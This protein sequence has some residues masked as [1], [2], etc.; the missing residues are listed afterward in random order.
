MEA[1]A[2]P[3]WEASSQVAAS[4]LQLQQIWDKALKIGRQIL[5]PRKKILWP[6]KKI[7]WPRKKILWPRKKILWPRKKKGTNLMWLETWE[8]YVTS[9]FIYLEIGFRISGRQLTVKASQAEGT[10][11]WRVVKLDLR[12]TNLDEYGRPLLNFSL[13]GKIDSSL[14]HLQHLTYL[15]LSGSNFVNAIPDFFGSF[16]HLEYL[17]LSYSNF[18]GRIPNQLGNLSNLHTLDLGRNF[19]L[20][21][22]DDFAWASSLSSLQFL[23][24]S[25]V[26]LSFSELNWLTNFSSLTHLY[27]SYG[28]FHG[29]MPPSMGN[30]TSLEVLDLSHNS[31][32]GTIPASFS[33]NLCK[34]RILNLGY[35]T[36]ISGISERWIGSI[37]L[38]NSLQ[39][40]YLRGID[41]RSSSTVLL[42]TIGNLTSLEVLDL[43]HNFI[44]GTLPRSL[45]NNLCH[46]IRGMERLITGLSN[47]LE[48]L[49]LGG[50]QLGGDLQVLWR[51]ISNISR[52]L[53]ILDLSDNS[54][55]GYIPFSS[56]NGGTKVPYVL[57][58][59]KLSGHRICFSTFYWPPA[60]V[61]FSFSS[62]SV[63]DPSLTMS[64]TKIFPSV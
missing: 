16:E 60:A 13:G 30:L 50:N 4:N 33:T 1:C 32:Y 21:V 23:D 5:W 17:N 43:S 56:S 19:Y 42:S 15:D 31:I 9:L 52:N 59:N 44:N 55:T 64:S 2:G 51:E 7:L 58:G 34:L 12:N 18:V 53:K 54:L 24:L 29:S 38:A 45:T 37:C 63:R 10:T 35:N 61:A 6:R 8:W 27:L 11:T 28:G 48:E 40:L 57:D 26:S 39:E 14:I 47:S 36:N 25:R 20:T 22:D 62:S 46:S 49:R 41:M 3:T